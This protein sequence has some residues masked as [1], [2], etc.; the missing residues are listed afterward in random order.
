MQKLV[1]VYLE[2]GAYAKGRMIVTGYADMHGLAEE[3]LA[4]YLAEG[5]SIKTLT[6]LG[7]NSESLTV[8][9]WLAVVL[10]K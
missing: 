8:R 9:G 1:T 4:N 7:G 6:A 3:H 10:E 5:W 2:N